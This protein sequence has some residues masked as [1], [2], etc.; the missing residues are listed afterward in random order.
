M[1]EGALTALQ[2]SSGSASG[3]SLSASRNLHSGIKA[4][5]G[6]FAESRL[7]PRTIH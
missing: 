6:L 2:A 3:A 4:E 7:A 5:I 1:T